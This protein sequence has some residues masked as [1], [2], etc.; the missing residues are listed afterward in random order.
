MTL[1]SPRKLPTTAWENKE[2]LLP[3]TLTILRKEGG[4]Y[5]KGVD[6]SLPLP[7]RGKV[8]DRH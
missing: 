1:L 3:P 2:Y 6:F 4:G 8:A 7:F 5:I